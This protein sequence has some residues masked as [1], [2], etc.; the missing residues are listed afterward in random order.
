MKVFDIEV[1]GRTMLG[2]S[3]ARKIKREGF[4]PGVL[5]QGNYSRPISIK[6]EEIRHILDKNRNAFLLNVKFRG[7]TFHAKVQ[8]VQREP[9]NDGII[10]IDLMPVDNAE[11]YLQ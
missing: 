2:S 6:E 5:Y 1:T 11:E 4:I 7:K 10:H 9:L 3:G 8:Q